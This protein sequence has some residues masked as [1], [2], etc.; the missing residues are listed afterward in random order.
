MVN[1][2]LLLKGKKKK[3]FSSSKSNFSTSNIHK[4]IPNFFWH[5]RQSKNVCWSERGIFVAGGSAIAELK[6]ALNEYLSVLIGL[7]KKGF[8]NQHITIFPLPLFFSP[9]L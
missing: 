2:I 7:T 3:N 9:Y 4:E 5:E 8:T 1:F 6:R